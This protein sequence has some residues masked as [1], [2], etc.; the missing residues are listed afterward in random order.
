MAIALVVNFFASSPA[1]DLTNSWKANAAIA[2]A[3]KVVKGSGIRN[4][5]VNCLKYLIFITD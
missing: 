2:L 3:V 4:L 5:P 1:P